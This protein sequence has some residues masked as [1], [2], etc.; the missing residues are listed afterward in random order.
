MIM[1]AEGWLPLAM[2]AP[3]SESECCAIFF[4]DAL[5]QLVEEVGAT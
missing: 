4:G 1:P 5:E 3:M 2:E